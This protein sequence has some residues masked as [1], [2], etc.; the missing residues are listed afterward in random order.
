MAA[1]RLVLLVDDIPEYL[2]AEELLVPEG[3]RVEKALSAEQGRSLIE[4]ETPDVAVIDVRLDEADDGNRQG[5]ELLRWAKESWPTLPIIMVSAYQEFEFQAE[6]L[7]LGAECF[8]TKPI[9]PDEF[10]EA[11]A[12]ALGTDNE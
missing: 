5:L 8:L 3:C 4:K 2:E 11:I 10:A 6:S 9:R 7:A 1:G 12:R